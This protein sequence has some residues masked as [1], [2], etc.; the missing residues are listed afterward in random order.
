MIR[1]AGTTMHHLL[2]IR[3]HAPI[4]LMCSLR[5]KVLMAD[6][7][8]PSSEA[9]S[10]SA[11]AAAAAAEATAREIPQGG[12]SAAAAASAAAGL[13]PARGPL[14]FRDMPNP[15]LR[16]PAP[17]FIKQPQPARGGPRGPASW[18]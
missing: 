9:S 1:L 13:A 4:C 18:S 17:V 12:G 8:G 16:T 5:R 3:L 14:V 15:S 2:V 6:G 11:A 7:A 10:A